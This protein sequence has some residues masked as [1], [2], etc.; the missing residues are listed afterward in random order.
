MGDYKL[1]SAVNEVLKSKVYL[2]RKQRETISFA[3]PINIKDENI[4]SF[5]EDGLPFKVKGTLITPGTYKDPRFGK[6]S[7]KSEELKKISDK[8]NGI[9][10]FKHH[11]AFDAIVRNQIYDANSSIDNVVGVITRSWWDEEK[12]AIL[13]EA[14]IDDS[15][16]A[17]KIARGL[18]KHVSVSFL[19]EKKPVVGGFELYD[20]KPL[21]LSLVYKPR[22]KNANIEPS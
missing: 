22:D 16:I 12:Q 21:E 5:S 1:Y 11:G 10:I 7:I 19:H 8:W 6:F 15:S 3:A 17:H 18:I 14:E 13:Y 2:S 4:T 9:N 20:L